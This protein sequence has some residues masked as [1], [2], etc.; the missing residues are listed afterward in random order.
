M[1]LT[2]KQTAKDADVYAIDE[3][4]PRLVSELRAVLRRPHTT[5]EERIQQARA[6]LSALPGVHHETFD[7]IQP[8][9]RKRMERGG[10]APW[11]V[12]CLKEYIEQRLAGHLTGAELAG[13]VGLSEHHFCRA[14]RV[15][16]GHAPHA[17]VVRRRVERAC[18]M[19]LSSKWTIGHIA[20]ECG[21]ADQAHL[22]R[23]FRSLMGTS[24]GVWRRAQ[25]EVTNM[26]RRT[27]GVNLSDRPRSK[28]GASNASGQRL[29]NSGMLGLR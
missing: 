3:P 5:A 24:P 1:Q 7:A 27:T 26:C 20:S 16:I 21:F 18:H 11:Q 29:P 25:I 17:Y 13:R 28:Y 4:M 12:R 8:V 9:A 2:S 6:I 22:N 23:C 10:L 19:M 14:F 15:S